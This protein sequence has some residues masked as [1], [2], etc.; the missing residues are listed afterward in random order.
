MPSRGAPDSFTARA[1]REYCVVS[2]SVIEPPKSDRRCAMWIMFDARPLHGF[3]S[4]ECRV[5]NRNSR[6]YQERSFLG[7][8]KLVRERPNSFETRLPTS[9]ILKRFFCAKDLR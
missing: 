7:E 9:V 6:E 5:E 8:M 1:S 3:Y 4:A 2:F